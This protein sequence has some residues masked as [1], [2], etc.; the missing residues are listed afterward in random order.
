MLPP[1]LFSST[2]LKISR[3]QRLREHTAPYA[4]QLRQLTA[5]RSLQFPELRLVQFDSGKLEALAV[6]LQKLKS[7]GRR[8]LILSQMVLMLDILEMFL[9]FHYLTYIRI[10]ENA[11]S[12][13]RQELMRSFNRDR[14]VFCALLSTHSRATGISLVEADTVVFYDNDL[15]P[16]M[17]AKAQEWCDRIGRCKDIHIYR[18]VSGNSIEEKLLKNGTKDLIREVAAQGNDY[19]MA[20]LTQRTI[21]E[22]F[23]VH[24]PLDDTGFPVKAEEFVVLSQEPTVSETIAPKIAR[25]FIEALKSIEDLEEDTQKTAEE[26]VPGASAGLST[27][28]VG[29]SRCEE[30]PSQLEELADL[31]EQL[32]PIEK[33]ALN[34]LELFHTT[35]DQER[36]RNSE[37]AVLTSVRDWEAHNAQ[38]LQEREAQLQREQEEAELLTYTREDAYSM[39]YVYEDAEGQ[40]EVMPLWTPPTPPQDDN[41]VYI[42]SVMCLMYEATPIP[43]AKLPPVYVRKER[44]R[45]KTDPSA[46]GRKKKQR[47]GEA[48]V[49]PRSLFDR[50]TPGMLKMRR[51]GKEQKKN[52]LLKQQAPFAKPLPTCVKSSGEPAQDS[53]EWLIG[54]D[55]ALLQAVKQLL[56]LPLNLTIVSPAHTPNWDLVSDVVNSCSRIYRSSKQCRSRYENVIIPREEG[57]SKNNRPLRTSQ[58]YAQDENATHTQLFSS[59]FDLMKTTAGK[60][61]PPI[62]PLLGMNPFQ[63]NPKHASVLSERYFCVCDAFLTVWS[64]VLIQ[65][66]LASK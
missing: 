1:N 28:E 41:D 13:Q 10:D 65:H 35:V 45:H 15:N 29:S 49:P 12:E 18:L 23:E 55:W 32:T 3:W 33:Y 20:F 54:E 19:S 52:L 58:I 56:E 8:V 66:P 46:A 9:N 21:Q 40:T 6:L 2:V 24:S 22:L 48:V 63:K 50:A 47:H 26:A 38:I 37:D 62:K 27:S 42:D 31:M 4:Q 25:P 34:Y 30:E 59:H 16:V 61:S 57:K 53:P 11:N 17:D 36:E 7:E 64:Q 51:E 60:R 39:E 5:L 14:R 44:K 43:E